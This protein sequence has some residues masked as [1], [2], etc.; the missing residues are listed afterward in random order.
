[1]NDLTLKNEIW[2]ILETIDTNLHDES[3]YADKI[4]K[5]HIQCEIDL[6]KDCIEHPQKPGYKRHD[7]LK[8]IDE[9]ELKLI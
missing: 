5:L 8:K 7:I 1:M 4:Y 3:F 2:E 6:L 9:L